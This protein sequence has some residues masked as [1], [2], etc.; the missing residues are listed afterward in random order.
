[1]SRLTSVNTVISVLGGNQRVAAITHSNR[2]VVTNWKA[3]QRFPAATYVA[4]TVALKK[5]GLS[6]DTELWAMRGTKRRVKR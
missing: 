4:L 1:M 3:A 6:A 5:M 2:K